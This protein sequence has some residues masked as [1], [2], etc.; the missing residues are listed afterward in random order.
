MRRDLVAL[1]AERRARV[2]AE[3]CEQ[4]RLLEC[5]LQEAAEQAS[6]RAAKQARVVT[7][8]GKLMLMFVFG[9]LLTQRK[10]QNGTTPN[11]SN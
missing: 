3:A 7:G 6:V 4:R 1:E 9:L 10:L 11:R 5:A 8:V 2:E